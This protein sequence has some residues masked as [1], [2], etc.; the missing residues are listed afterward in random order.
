[1]HFLSSFVFSLLLSAS[2]VTYASSTQAVSVTLPNQNLVLNYSQPIRLD[3]AILDANAQVNFYSLGA[4]LSDNQL[5]KDI[6]N[7]RNNSIEQL[8]SLSRET[9]LFSASNEFKRSATQIISQLEHHTFVGRIFSPLDLD[10]IRINEKLNPILNADYQ[11]FVHPRPTSVSFFGAID[12][13]TSISV[14]FIE[15]ASIDDYLD[16]LPLSSTAD[17][18]TVYVIQPDG[19]VQTTEFSVWQNKPAYLAPGASV[20]IPLG[21]LPSGF[22]S[23]NTSIVQLLRNKAL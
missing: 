18:S 3:Q 13:E 1:M 7:L 22:S 4:V 5:Q 21:G 20:Y 8:S 9:S 17:T 14:P 19:V 6:D 23:L 11:L 2:T 10:L 15:H 16:S 12:S